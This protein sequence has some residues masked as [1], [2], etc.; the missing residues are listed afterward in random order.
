[1]P[2]T[3]TA[4]GTVD[5][6]PEY[7]EF[8]SGRGT[9]TLLIHGAPVVVDASA[10]THPSPFMFS[11]QVL[12]SESAQTVGLLPGG[13][14][15]GYNACCGQRPEVTIQIGLDGTVDYDPLLEGVLLGQGTSSLTVAGATFSI[16]ATNLDAPSFV[17]G[18][19]IR[20]STAT[21]HELTVIPGPG[22]FLPGYQ[23]RNGVLARVGSTQ[24]L[25]GVLESVAAAASTCHCDDTRTFETAA[26][27]ASLAATSPCVH[28]HC[29]WAPGIY[30]IAN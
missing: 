11:A 23:L 12:S 25:Q 16:D 9:S 3:V 2:F 15:V 28:L 4:S 17:V 7:D 8:L 10:L 1:M 18:S 6:D 22:N 14:F 13:H 26:F 30:Q 24:Q 19:Y 27:S 29:P 20:L 5:I 21:V